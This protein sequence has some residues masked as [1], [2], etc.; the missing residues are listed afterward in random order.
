MTAMNPEETA[1]VTPAM[2][3]GTFAQVSDP[4]QLDAHDVLVFRRLAPGRYAHLGGRGRGE[5]WAG[6]V[7]VSVD[8]EPLLREAVHGGRPVRHDSQRP[9]RVI[10][11][12]YARSAVLVEVSDDLVV[13]LG[14]QDGS[15][16]LI[17]APDVT[18]LTAARTASSAVTS[19]PATK[20]LADELEVLHAVQQMMQ[21]LSWDYDATLQHVALTAAESLSCELGVLLTHDHH[22]AIATRGWHAPDREAVRAVV[23]P[24]LE[25]LTQP[26]CV[27]AAE[28]S[29]L[30]GPLSPE[31]GVL[32]YYL[33]PLAAPASGLLLLA[34]TVVMPRGFTALCQRLGVQLAEAA[35]GLIHVAAMRHQS[36]EELAQLSKTA[37]RD[38]VTGAANRLAWEEALVVAQ[39]RVDHGDPVT[40]LTL[41]LDGLK[42]VNDS[43]GHPAGDQLLA[44]FA[45][46][47]RSAIR[48]RD[49]IARIGGDEFGVL[50]PGTDEPAAGA[51]IERIET[52]L[53]EHVTRGQPIA[54]SLGWT[55]CPPGGRLADAVAAADAAMYSEKRRRRAERA[56]DAPP[57]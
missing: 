41:D 35:A 31:D 2:A 46:A 42:A 32:S 50:L 15:A 36:Q 52:E 47:V 8:S 22:L 9:S 6:I 33:V 28:L 3:P 44:A 14:N 56:G 43:R 38:A 30:P 4:A 13:V 45:R 1:G 57:S 48:E 39:H 7:E 16:R 26:V 18:L 53:A 24:L 40:V 55:T 49:F 20:R 19:V 54:A 12:Y 10:G 34:H 25:Q 11:P 5:G 23:A 27:Q 17:G 21:A 51:V 37:R 29:P